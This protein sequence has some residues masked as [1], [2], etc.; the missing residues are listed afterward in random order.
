M[1]ET[2]Y[3]NDVSKCREVMMCGT[4]S[5]LYG[6]A[7]PPSI[8]GNRT[9]N[10]NTTGNKDGRQQDVTITLTINPPELSFSE[11]EGNWRYIGQGLSKFEVKEGTS[12]SSTE[13]QT[14]SNS[15]TEGLK[16]SATQKSDMVWGEASLT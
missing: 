9:F 2:Y 8:P 14:Y 16:F 4:N 3:A 13:S 1:G 5:G 11:Y 7:C 6:N 10:F 15:Y 12:W